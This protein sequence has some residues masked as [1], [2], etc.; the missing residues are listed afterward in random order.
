MS[1]IAMMLPA[2]ALAG[3]LA[4]VP[5]ADAQRYGGCRDCGTVTEVAR[6]YDNRYEQRYA[7]A[8][9]PLGAGAVVGAIVG[10]LVGNQVGD[11]SGRTLATVAGALAGGAVGHTVQGRRDAQAARPQDAYQVTVRMD[12]GRYVALNQYSGYGLRPGDRVQVQGREAV[13]FDGR[14]DRDWRE[15]PRYTAYGH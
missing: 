4:W 6:S 5:S 9:R 15:G 3:A 14:N 8:Q 11:G 1:R 10:G 7:S 2:A 12:D 13:P